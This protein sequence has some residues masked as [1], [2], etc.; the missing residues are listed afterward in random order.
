MCLW[1]SD[2][3]WDDMSRFKQ[4]SDYEFHRFKSQS[5]STTFTWGHTVEFPHSPLCSSLSPV[6]RTVKGHDWCSLQLNARTQQERSSYWAENLPTPEDQSW[7]GSGRSAETGAKDFFLVSYLLSVSS[8]GGKS[9]EDPRE[10]FWSS[11][12]FSCIILLV[13]YWKIMLV[14]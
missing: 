4:T 10:T 8:W 1:G 12:M 9:H 13:S 7:T 11:A 5:F 2:V 6:D 14:S 3:F